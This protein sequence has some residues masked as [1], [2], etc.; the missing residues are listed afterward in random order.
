MSRE[1]FAG[2]VNADLAKWGKT[3]KTLNIH[4]E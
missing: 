3:V 4:A 2:I 1:E